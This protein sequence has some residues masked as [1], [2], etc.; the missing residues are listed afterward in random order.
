VALASAALRFLWVF[1]AG[2]SAVCEAGEVRFDGHFDLSSDF[3]DAIVHD[4]LVDRASY[5]AM[6]VWEFS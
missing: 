5:S 4:D 1:S 2:I 3:V 6:V